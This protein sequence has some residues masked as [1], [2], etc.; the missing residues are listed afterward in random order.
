MF[1][2]ADFIQYTQ[3]SGI[4]TLV[5]ALLTVL[6][7]IFKWGLRFRLVGST[8]FMLVLTA[9][10]FTLSLAPL[11]RTVIPGA[12]RYH[13]VY[14]NGSTQ[15]VIAISPQITPTQLEATLRQAANDLYSYGRLG[16][17]GDNQLTIRARTIVH[18]EPGVSTPL[19]LGQVQR[20]L[21]SREDSQMAID[22]YQ[23]KFAQLPK[24]N[25]TSS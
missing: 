2:Q 9:G 25:N 13:L 21:A 19:Y 18:P 23:D 20:S 12:V 17:P 11:T 10:L 7:F 3:W 24:S 22:I 16:K 5:F 15:T 14:D 1:S 8:G 4:A 6:G